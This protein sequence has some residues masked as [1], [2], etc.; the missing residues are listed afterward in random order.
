MLIVSG[1]ILLFGI[2]GGE[3]IIILLVILL[4][5]GP[6]KIPE[7]ARLL[8]KGLKE[9]KKVQREINIEFNKY[10]E[11]SNSKVSEDIQRDIDE[12]KKQRNHT[13]NEHLENSGETENTDDKT[14]DSDLPY[15]YNKSGKINED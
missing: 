1:N 15:P 3:I 10:S 9:V 13:E 2:S 11:D 6:K 4:V 7:I 12:F 8:G 5:F 14:D